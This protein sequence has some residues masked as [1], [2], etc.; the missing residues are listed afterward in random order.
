MHLFRPE[1][2]S[3]ITVSPAQYEKACFTDSDFFYGLAVRLW[4]HSVGKTLSKKALSWVSFLSQ[5]W[6]Q[7]LGGN[8]IGKLTCVPLFSVACPLANS[9]MILEGIWWIG[10]CG[11]RDTLPVDPK[12]GHSLTKP[13]RFGSAPVCPFC[14][15]KVWQLLWYSDWFQIITVIH[16]EVCRALG[17]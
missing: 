6:L 13:Q 7:P 15:A 9:Q 11:L 8:V 14:L 1:G 5:M 16:L 2:L 12:T 10:S 3:Q 17:R 4:D